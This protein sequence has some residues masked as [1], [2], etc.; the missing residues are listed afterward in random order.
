MATTNDGIKSVRLEN[1]QI[2]AADDGNIHLTSDD[3]DAKNLHTYVTNNPTSKRYHPSAYR[4]LA[5]ILTKFGK[6]VPGWDPAEGD[7]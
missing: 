2:W 6:T 5:R 3:P 4:Q 7:E 1:V